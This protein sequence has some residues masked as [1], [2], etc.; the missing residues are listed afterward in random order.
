MVP[1]AQFLVGGTV[2]GRIRRYG[3]IGGGVSLGVGFEPEGP[4]RPS[5]VLST[6]TCA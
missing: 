4:S 3:L 6:P 2:L 5:L 1:W